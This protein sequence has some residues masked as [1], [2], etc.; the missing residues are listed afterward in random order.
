M[1]FFSK[2][3][4]FRIKES[5]LRPTNKSIENVWSDSLDLPEAQTSKFEMIL[6]DPKSQ[7]KNSAAD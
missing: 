7:K 6:N 3:E 5:S 1:D 2:I 4:N